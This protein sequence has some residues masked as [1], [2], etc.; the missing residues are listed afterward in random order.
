V[1][2]SPDLQVVPRFALS[3][4]E[5]SA[6]SLDAAD[7][8]DVTTAADAAQQHSTE[9]RAADLVSVICESRYPRSLGKRHVFARIPDGETRRRLSTLAEQLG[10]DVRKHTRPPFSP[11]RRGGRSVVRDPADPLEALVSLVSTRRPGERLRGRARRRHRLPPARAFAGRRSGA[12]TRSPRTVPDRQRGPTRVA[13]PSAEH[14]G[15]VDHRGTHDGDQ[16]R[17]LRE[18]C[19]VHVEAPF[20]LSLLEII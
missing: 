5:N 2:P 16:C 10:A 3:E 7:F 18:L 14:V 19:R 17:E 20:W 4:T 11:H 13:T 12:Q 8:D 6:Q 1:V 9:I 15:A